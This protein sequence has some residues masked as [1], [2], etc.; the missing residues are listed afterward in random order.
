MR[1]NGAPENFVAY[2]QNHINGKWYNYK[3]DM[4]TL[5]TDFKEQVINNAIP[6]ILFYEKI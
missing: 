2:C 3:D 5:V 6:Y 4:V 1:L